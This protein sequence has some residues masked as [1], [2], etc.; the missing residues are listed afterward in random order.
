M[1]SM[2]RKPP[3]LLLILFAGCGFLGDPGNEPKG[4][5]NLPSSGVGKFIKQDFYCDAEFIQPFFPNIGDPVGQDWM[6]GEPC[7]VVQ[8][9][10]VR[11]WLERRNE[12]TAESRIHTTILGLGRG[13]G[14]RDMDAWEALP[15]QEVVFDSDPGPRVGAPTVYHAGGIYKMWFTEGDGAAI[16]VATADEADCT[17]EDCHAWHLH[18]EPVL[19][20]NQDWERGTVGSPTVVHYNGLY[21]MYYDG[22]VYQERAIGYA[23]SRDGVT[24]TKSDPQGHESGA[25]DRA[26]AVRNVQPVLRATQTNWEFWYPDPSYGPDY[27]GRVGQPCV[28]IH[29]SPLRTFLLMYYTGNLKGK[30]QRPKEGD[31]SAFQIG[32]DASIGIAWSQDGINWE[33]APSFSTPEVIA[34]EINPIVSEK[35]AISFDLDHVPGSINVF[36]TMFIINEAAPAVL[37]LIPEQF[38]IM[39]W[40]QTD[41]INLYWAPNLPIPPATDSGYKGSSGIGFAFEGNSP[42]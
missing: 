8:D 10:S 42:F 12:I 22:D 17:P 35:H 23:W 27:I 7:M 33:K 26:P 36:T 20:P 15:L 34:M 25:A 30:L 41:W 9:G 14:C 21:R 40:E 28:I 38:F 2:K 11:V 18:A 29:S 16:R 1:K 6:S 37:E 3:I 13:T 32:M 5:N 24:W 4:N 31:G 19:V 39:L